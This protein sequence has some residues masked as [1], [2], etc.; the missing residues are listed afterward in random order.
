M[1]VYRC[2]DS[3]ESIFTAIYLAYEEKRNHAETMLSLSDDPI[4]FAED[5][6]VVSCTD[7]VLK[8]IKTLKRRFGEDDYKELCLA[9]A[10]GIWK[11]RRRFTGRWQ[12]DWRGTV[13][14][15]IFLTI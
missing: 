14:V 8:V 3:L 13:T 10:S 9:L 1:I 7:K 12:T 11:R 6:P 15:G 2:E 5:V 4:L